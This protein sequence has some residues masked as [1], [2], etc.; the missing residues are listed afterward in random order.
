MDGYNFYN[1]PMMMFSPSSNGHCQQHRAMNPMNFYN[2]I[3]YMPVD[4]ND[5]CFDQA[6]DTVSSLVNALWVSITNFFLF[7]QPSQDEMDTKESDR[8]QENTT[9][10]TVK[11]EH[12][13]GEEDTNVEAKTNGDLHTLADKAVA[14]DAAE[15]NE[16]IDEGVDEVI[17][18]R[19]KCLHHI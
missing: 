6:T 7:T 17:S 12:T 15:Q 2:N 10:E 13:N 9:K 8:T 3:Q 16:A 19:N 5:K 11:T 1:G 4:L 18:Q 14:N